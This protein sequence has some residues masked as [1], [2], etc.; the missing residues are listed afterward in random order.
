MIG[1]GTLFQPATGTYTR[2]DVHLCSGDS[3]L[4][5]Q[6]WPAPT[7]II[8]D[9]PYGIGSFPGDP[10]T[11]DS[12][13]EWYRPH[14]QVWSSK[15]TPQTSL[16]FWNTELGWA[17]VHPVFL[18]NG[19]EYRSCHVWDKGIAHVAGNSNGQTLRKF[20]VV[21]EVCVHY[22]RKAEFQVNGSKLDM[23]KWLRHEWF[24]TGLPL[25]KANEACR[26]KNAA[27]RKY[28][29]D[30]HLWYYPPPE[31]F[32]QLAKY[33]NRFG[34][35]AGRPYFSI[36]GR[37]PMTREAW[38]QMRSKFNFENRVTNVWRHPSVRG[39]ERLKQNSRC[40]HLNQKPLSLLEL[41]IRAT[42]D[43][44]DVVWEP[45]GGLCSVAVAARKL[46]RACY[47]AEVLPEF[48]A[49]SCQRLGTYDDAGS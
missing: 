14:V 38:A 32:E 28:L 26:V 4:L 47:S 7:V 42:S 33:A 43:R 44:G 18:E 20:P 41:I 11:P 45:F 23:K 3:L 24:R 37:R 13:A 39:S 48:F 12:L 19:W 5:C 8:V 6:S 21:T 31:M 1:M 16:W 40:V 49:Y 29:T 46:R 22:V 34:G 27:T 9:G 30:D 25:Y 2:D 35:K 10:P 17:T 36:D 15:S